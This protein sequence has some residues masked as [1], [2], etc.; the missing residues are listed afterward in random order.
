MGGEWC[1]VPPQPDPAISVEAGL[2]VPR[3]FFCQQTPCSSLAHSTSVFDGCSGYE[4]LGT[5]TSN[6]ATSRP[7]RRSPFTR[8]RDSGDTTPCRITG[9]TLHSHVHYTETLYCPGIASHAKRV[10]IQHL[11]AMKFTTHHDF[12]RNIK[13]PCCNF[14]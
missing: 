11:W 10:L 9:V 7:G 8:G 6:Q 5:T 2:S 3:H 1:V 12:V 4:R 13:H 14:H